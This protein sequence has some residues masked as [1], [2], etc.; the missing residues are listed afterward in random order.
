MS[1]RKRLVEEKEFGTVECCDSVSESV[2]LE[3]GWTV[4]AVLDMVGW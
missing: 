2:E 4:G 1:E 3:R